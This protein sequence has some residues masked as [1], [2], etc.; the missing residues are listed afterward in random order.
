MFETN[1]NGSL[2]R[3]QKIGLFFLSIFVILVVFLVYL[4][5]RNNIIN[6][7]SI[8]IEEKVIKEKVDK[9][10]EKDILK[11]IDTDHDGLTDYDELNVYNTSPYL[12]D[13]D[14]DG[15]NDKDEI[16]QGTNPLC[17]K[18]ECEE[19]NEENVDFNFETSTNKNNL[20]FNGAEFEALKQEFLDQNTNS[21]NL[22][23]LD[24]QTLLSDPKRLRELLIS[25]GN[26]S[27]EDLEG[28][29]DEELL[30]LAK[31]IISESFKE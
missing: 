10:K 1:I 12:E 30:N 6:P 20:N 8:D 18:E 15:V 19:I 13:T 7:L 29:S 21:N 31:S 16:T 17:F 5:F 3:E 28:V 27:A 22:N 23:D 24:I 25:T 11:N 9:I 26:L 4:Q 14:S 2:N